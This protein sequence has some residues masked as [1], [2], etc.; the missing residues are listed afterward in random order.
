MKLFSR[1]LWLVALLALGGACFSAMTPQVRAATTPAPTAGV[2]DVPLGSTISPGAQI[3]PAV[4]SD[5]SV[6]NS[7][8]SI[9]GIFQK[10]Y[11]KV[12]NL[13]SVLAALL[14]VFLLVLNGIRYITAGG[15][16][17]KIKT[18][19]ANI[20]SVVIGIIIIVSAYFIIRLA[21]VIGATVSKQG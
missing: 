13:I 2:T 17:A 1:A 10:L 4:P 12:F 19:R 18:A 8:G 7:L 20:V 14:A 9:S 15:D 5:G 3:A 16:P 21:L 6:S 11:S